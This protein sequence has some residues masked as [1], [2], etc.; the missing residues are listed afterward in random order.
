MT[1][2]EK[3]KEARMQACL[4]QEQLAEKLGISRSAVAK[5]ETDKGIP[6]IE[7]LK[8]ISKL[9]KVSIDYLLDDGEAI[10]ELV[11]CEPFSLSDCGKGSKGKKKDRA[12]REKFPDSEIHTLLGEMKLTKGEKVIDNALGFLTDAPFGIP[13]IINSV[14]NSDKQFY[15]IEKDGKQF[16]VTVTDEFIETRRL[17]NRVD[18]KKFEIGNWKFTKCGY[19]VK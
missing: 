14:K 1:L 6:D 5:W 15:L 16:L 19:E 4:S 3:L 18:G 11:M 13:G 8:L 2:G 7:N 10:D 17:A 9:L 12:V